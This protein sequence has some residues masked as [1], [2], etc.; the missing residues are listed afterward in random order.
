MAKN[1]EDIRKADKKMVST[2][3]GKLSFLSPV[4]SINNLV[5]MAGIGGKMLLDKLGI[6][7]TNTYTSFGDYEEL[8]KHH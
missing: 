3:A 5:A 2:L 4:E 6:T 8:P 7:N 1:E